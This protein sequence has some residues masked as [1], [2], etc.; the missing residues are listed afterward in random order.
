MTKRPA[1]VTAYM[2]AMGF[3]AGPEAAAKALKAAEDE[4]LNFVAK[5][6]LYVGK[7]AAKESREELL[8]L[9]HVVES[10]AMND[11]AERSRGGP[12]AKVKAK[13]KKR[14]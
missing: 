4:L 9:L 6:E 8:R 7:Q 2:K 5:G 11:L 14:L 1:N 10:A 13:A 12:T 3:M